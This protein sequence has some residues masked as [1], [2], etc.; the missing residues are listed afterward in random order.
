M[1]K[2]KA[3][4]V[5]RIFRTLPEDFCSQ[6]KK[7]LRKA[8]IPINA[9]WAALRA[10]QL[11]IWLCSILIDNIIPNLNDYTRFVCWHNDME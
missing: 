8:A 7:T 1:A 6:I 10:F 4:L 9:D 11:S 5:C 2:N 3:V